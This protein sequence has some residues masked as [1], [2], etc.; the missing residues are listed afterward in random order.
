M[1]RTLLILQCRR[2]IIASIELSD[3]KPMFS[4]I[5]NDIIE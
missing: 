5:L 4:P 2:K 1:I 3:S